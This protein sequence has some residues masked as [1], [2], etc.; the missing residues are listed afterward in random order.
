MGGALSVIP[1]K[2]YNIIM[3]FSVVLAE[4]IYL[5]ILYVYATIATPYMHTE[6][7]LKSGKRCL[8]SI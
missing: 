3:L 6:R 7:P 1:H 5:T 4:V 2:G 8:L